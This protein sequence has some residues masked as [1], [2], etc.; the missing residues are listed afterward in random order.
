MMDSV[1]RNHGTPAF[2]GAM[3]RRVIDPID[4]R[5]SKSYMLWGSSL[6]SL[7]LVQ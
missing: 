1:Y 7:L 5:P 4:H 6:L 3:P 2:P